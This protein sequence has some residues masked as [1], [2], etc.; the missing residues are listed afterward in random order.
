ML[1]TTYIILLKNLFWQE[2]RRQLEV[3]KAE[4]KRPV[5]KPVKNKKDSNRDN[6]NKEEKVTAFER[7]L[8]ETSWL[9]AGALQHYLAII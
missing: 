8:Q 9:D 5:R 6:S 4:V 1:V 7:D 2:S 3:D